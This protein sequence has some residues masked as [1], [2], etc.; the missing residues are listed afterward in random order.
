MF[1]S[2]CSASDWSSHLSG[3]HVICINVH[4]TK[5]IFLSITLVTLGPNTSEDDQETEVI[6]V[7]IQNEF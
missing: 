7:E 3:Y 5:S 4:P 6:G 2:V 1:A